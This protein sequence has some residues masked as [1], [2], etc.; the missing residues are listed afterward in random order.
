V[1]FGIIEIDRVARK[2]ESIAGP[3]H[4]FES[5]RYSKHTERQHYFR[6]R[7]NRTNARDGN[8]FSQDITAT[9]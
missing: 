6:E 4:A 7:P 8:F 1:D 3:T 2:V 9:D 5:M